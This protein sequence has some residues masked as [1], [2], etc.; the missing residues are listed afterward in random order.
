MIEDLDIKDDNRLIIELIENKG[1][2][3][4]DETISSLNKYVETNLSSL[5]RITE[6]LTGIAAY[7][8]LIKQEDEK[9][10]SLGGV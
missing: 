7:R 5:C 1:Y 8:T 6:I 4:D 2:N 9:I 3:L 10:E